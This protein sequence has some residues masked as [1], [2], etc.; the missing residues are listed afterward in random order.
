MTCHDYYPEFDDLASDDGID[1]SFKRAI[2]DLENFYRAFAFANHATNDLGHP[3]LPYLSGSHQQFFSALEEARMEDKASIRRRLTALSEAV[4][5][6][7]RTLKLA[8]ESVERASGAAVDEYRRKALKQALKLA[9]RETKK[10][11]ATAADA[12]KRWAFVASR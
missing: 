11:L 8:Q 7:E 9:D 10:L 4:H 1:R 2:A 12:A 6:V 5:A 3:H